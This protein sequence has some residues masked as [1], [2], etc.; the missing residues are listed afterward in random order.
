MA[1]LTDSGTFGPL[2]QVTSRRRRRSDSGAE[3]IELAIV[4]P[5]LLIVVAGIVDFG[6]LFQR[7]EAVTN[8]A[9]EGARVAVLPNFN[10]A[11]VQE[12]V[13][14]Y[15]DSSG[16][17]RTVSVVPVPTHT[18]VALATGATVDVVTVEVS[19]PAQFLYLGPFLQMVGGSHT[20]QIMLRA[21][22]VM[23]SESASVTGS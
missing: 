19:Y 10:D 23:R 12:R 15:L 17:D 7:F 6:F 5:I 2:D 16:L 22:S 13:K 8:A 20:N 4:L 21:R 18:T 3:L 9:R 14:Q 11:D 1:A